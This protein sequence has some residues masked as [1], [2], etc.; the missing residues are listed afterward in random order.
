[1]PFGLALKAALRTTSLE[2]RK[3]RVHFALRILEKDS[4]KTI[5]ML[6]DKNVKD[7]V[8]SYEVLKFEDIKPLLDI[9]ISRYAQRLHS[10]NSGEYR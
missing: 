9:W 10:L 3:L 8:E 2:D 4:D 5:V 6:L 1:M 7:D